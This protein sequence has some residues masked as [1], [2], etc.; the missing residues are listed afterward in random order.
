MNSNIEQLFVFTH[1]FYFYREVSFDRRP[2]NKSQN[3]HIIEK[4]NSVSQISYTGDHCTLKN[5]YSMMWDHLKKAK[6]TL[7]ADKSQNVML[8]NTMRRVIDSYLDFVGI[9]KTGTTITWSAINTFEEGT[10]EF[11]VES[12]FISLINDE[13]HGLAAMDDMYYESIV[14]Q[15]P[16]VIFNAFKSLFKEIGRSHYEYMMDEN[17]DE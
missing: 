12:A 15:E 17:F 4:N 16:I 5:D 14:K 8:A 10:P 11:I 7:G 1:N 6:E 2:I 3:H 13:S 9:K